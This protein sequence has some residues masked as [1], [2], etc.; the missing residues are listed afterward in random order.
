MFICYYINSDFT[1]FAPLIKVL[2]SPMLIVLAQDQ[3]ETV[4]LDDAQYLQLISSLHVGSVQ[5]KQFSVQCAGDSKTATQKQPILY[6]NHC[7][8]SVLSG[9]TH[10]MLSISSLCSL[11]LS[12]QHVSV[13]WTVAVTGVT[14]TLGYLFS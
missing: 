10:I 8:V 5:K 11:A 12:A 1:K 2:S 13:Q 4:Q 3:E 7:T 6:S 14:Y 9:S